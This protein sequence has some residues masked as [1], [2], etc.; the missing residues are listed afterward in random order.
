MRKINFAVIFGAE[1]EHFHDTLISLQAD[2]R[3]Y[4]G[5]V[6]TSDQ[7]FLKRSEKRIDILG[8]NF[9]WLKERGSCQKI[10]LVSPDL[11]IISSNLLK[12]FSQNNK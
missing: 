6:G 7:T 8:I 1:E 12:V 4:V 10:L 9:K 2:A 11:K 5:S 3:K